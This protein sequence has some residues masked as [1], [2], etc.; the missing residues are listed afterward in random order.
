MSVEEA[1]R[2]YNSVLKKVKTHVK[3][4]LLTKVNNFA[5]IAKQKVSKRTAKYPKE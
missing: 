3:T 1:D 5:N 2:S 4:K